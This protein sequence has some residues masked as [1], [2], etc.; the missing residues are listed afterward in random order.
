MFSKL[1]AFRN[2]ALNGNPMGVP[3]RLI[4]HRS[5]REFDPKLAAVLAFWASLSFA[6]L[7]KRPE[8]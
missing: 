5:N 1:L 2:I 7:K 3:T 8:N 4:C 6:Y